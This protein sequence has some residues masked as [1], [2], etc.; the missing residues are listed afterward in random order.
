MKKLVLHAA[1]FNTFWAHYYVNKDQDFIDKLHE[2][3]YGFYQSDQ[4]DLIDADI[5]LFCE[6]TSIGLYRFKLNHKIRYLAKLL[7]GRVSLKDRDIYAE[8]VKN[9]MIKK[10]ALCVAEG[11]VHMPQN[12]I[13]KLGKM[14]PVVFT[15]NDTMVDNIHFFK[16]CIPQPVRWP[17]FQQVPFSE[18]K[19]LVN[20]SANKYESHP[21]EL[22]AARRTSIR[23]FEDRFK[24]QF[25]LYGIGWNKAAT[26]AQRLTKNIPVYPSYKGMAAGKTEVFPKFRFA[27]CYENHQWPGYITEKIFDCMRSDCVPVYLGA[28]NITDYV[29]S[30]C[31]IDR[32]DFYDD[33][34]LA[35]FLLNVDEEKYTDYRKCISEYLLGS[36]FS[37][38]LCTTY[39]ETL[40]KIIENKIV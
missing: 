27:I 33:K 15:W 13:P 1:S 10:S 30:G 17:E 37:S 11:I 5:I 26:K 9:G 28:P 38:F 32:R 21:D 6:A 3:G 31:F 8:C 16:Y 34:Q 2:L 24:D 22:Y 29:P 4:I 39:A 35:S 36:K 7:L 12:H 40:I 19:L 14:F 23:Y 20:I 25:E 18:K